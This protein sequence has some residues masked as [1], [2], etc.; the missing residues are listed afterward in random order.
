MSQNALRFSVYIYIY[1][2]SNDI[3]LL[4]KTISID[5]NKIYKNIITISENYTNNNTLFRLSYSDLFFFCR[6]ICCQYIVFP[7]SY[8]CI[9]IRNGAVWS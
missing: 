6:M 2:N 9:Q 3:C 7:I 5:N 8:R 4:N 1:K